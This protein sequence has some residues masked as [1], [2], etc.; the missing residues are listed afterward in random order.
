MKI[1]ISIVIAAVLFAGCAEQAKLSQSGPLA[2]GDREETMLAKMSA[3]GAQD[4]TSLTPSQFIFQNTLEQR[5]YWWR[6]PDDTI[7]AVLLAGRTKR[8]LEVAIID[9][10]PP[11]VGIE[12]ITNWESLD[13]TQQRSI[14]TKESLHNKPDARDGL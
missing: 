6:L 8:K 1:R 10:S 12:G 14:E 9:T 5:Y 7:V 13:I 11:G 3:L 4:V 2:L